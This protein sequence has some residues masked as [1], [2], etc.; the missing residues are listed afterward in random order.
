MVERESTKIVVNT[1][2]AWL[3]V[4][5]LVLYKKVLKHTVCVSGGRVNRQF[6]E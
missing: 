3:G 5:G 2:G 4:G 6:H 1:C